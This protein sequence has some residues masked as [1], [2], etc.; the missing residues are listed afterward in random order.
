MVQ[1]KSQP[2]N[3]QFHFWVAA[4]PFNC[5]QAIVMLWCL[6]PRSHTVPPS[7]PGPCASPR[8]LLV[9]H[10]PWP[11]PELEVKYDSTWIDTLKTKTRHKKEHC[12]IHVIFSLLLFKKKL[13]N[14][15][16]MHR[17]S[18]YN[19]NRNNYDHHENSNQITWNLVELR[20]Y[21]ITVNI[22]E[23]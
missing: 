20:I 4:R 22:K 7:A 2:S 1:Q 16:E 23:Q 5:N 9:H 18:F 3:D 6:T 15:L 8:P 13:L 14:Y 21:K 17:Y 12:C 11:W 10:C 19:K